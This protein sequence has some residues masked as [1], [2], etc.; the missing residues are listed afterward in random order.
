MSADFSEYFDS[1]ARVSPGWQA[2]LEVCSKQ[3]ID[4]VSGYF[5]NEIP[6]N[7]DGFPQLI[8][9]TSVNYPKL[10]EA[11]REECAFRGVDMPA[12]YVDVSG[13]TR[14]GRANTDRYLFTVEDK[15]YEMFSKKE[16]RAL[17][18]HEL[19]H[20]YQPNYDTPE[21]SCLAEYDCDRAAVESVG[22]GTILTYV[23][24]VGATTLEKNFNDFSARSRARLNR[25]FSLPDSQPQDLTKNLAGQWSVACIAEDDYHPHP[26]KRL[27]AM[28]RHSRTVAARD[29][30]LDH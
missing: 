16:L 21:E 28:W 26:A 27:W 8:A 15:A 7:Q 6:V 25:V 1:Y 14:L 18:A 13:N 4:P 11:L 12:C 30:T 19:K 24:K 10:Y 22:F 5:P 17:C 9:V 29:F 3:G 2:Y 23:A 20:L